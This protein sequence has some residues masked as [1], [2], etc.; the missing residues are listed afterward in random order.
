MSAAKFPVRCRLKKCRARRNATVH[1]DDMKRQ[2]RCWK[3]GGLHGWQI[4]RRPEL[5]KLCD[6]GKVINQK[7]ATTIPHRVGGHPFCDQHPRGLLN[8]AI[9][10]G[11]TG[12]D[13]IDPAIYSVGREMKPDDPCPF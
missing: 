4:E 3:C 8:Q 6:C 7:D 11:L 9:K 13:L 1:P 12:D 5:R 10:A 2:V